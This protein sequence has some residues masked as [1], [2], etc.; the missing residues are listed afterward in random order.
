[1]DKKT[2]LAIVLSLIVIFTWQAIFCKKTTPQTARVCTT[3]DGDR[4]KTGRKRSSP[5]TGKAG[6]IQDRPVSK[7]CGDLRRTFP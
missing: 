2:V 5:A 7:G 3:R 1:M 6:S 4:S